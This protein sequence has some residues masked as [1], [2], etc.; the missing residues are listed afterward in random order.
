MN[1]GLRKKFGD[2]FSTTFLN[3]IQ[4][5]ISINARFEVFRG[6]KAI[7]SIRP[8]CL[9]EIKASFKILWV[10]FCQADRFACSF[11]LFDRELSFLH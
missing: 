2:L 3:E 8:I 1:I 6:S 5:F 7:N 11:Y 9:S 10:V 4:H